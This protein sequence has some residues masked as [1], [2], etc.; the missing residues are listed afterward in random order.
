[1]R[2]SALHP[3]ACVRRRSRYG[4]AA[5][6]ALALLALPA[7][8][9]ATGTPDQSQTRD[10]GSFQ[11]FLQRGIA[12]TFTAGISGALDQVD[13]GLFVDDSCP[14]AGPLTIAIQGVAGG[15]PSGVVLA[16]A[17]LAE[18]NVPAIG[19]GDVVSSVP[20]AVPA[21][22][23]AGT[24]YAIVASAPGAQGDCSAAG[25]QAYSWGTATGD[26]YP[27]GTGL[28]SFDDGVNWDA[29]GGGAID[30]AFT[31]YVSPVDTTAP[32]TTIGLGPSSPDG[33]NGWYVSPVTVTISTSDAS[34]ETRCV[35]DPA[36]VPASF[37]DLPAGCPASQT[38]SA[39]G[40]HVLYAASKDE[41]GNTEQIE[42]ASFKI[43][44]TSPTVTFSS[45]PA[46]Y[47]VDQ[48]VT[49]T[50][51]AADPS[52][53]SGLASNTCGQN[54]LGNVPAY[55]LAAGTH[56]LSATATDNAGNSAAAQTSYSVKV[57]IASLCTLT[58]RF[59]QGSAKYAAL[60]AKQKA[61]V[62]ALGQVTC[63]FLTAIGTKLN[64]K[65]TQV[66]IAGYKAGVGSLAKQGWL[67]TA[68][69]TTL[70]NLTSSL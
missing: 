66:L 18:A 70:R 11:I 44:R 29:Q 23:V 59:V 21:L 27:E 20:F 51:A 49:I 58:N 5:L 50:C 33:Q 32:A 64:A 57:T 19:T 62:N 47:T 39:D 53:G 8:A 26:P 15:V 67:S 37:S 63:G 43:D 68:Q 46:S 31:T 45:H 52:P 10:D 14:P 24:Q 38:V 56:T 61:S 69:A 60:T 6:A 7:V 9:S 41:A 17:T 3:S 12:Q 40:P 48:Q 2:R 22:V 54:S 30:L 4:L 35:V 28:I 25:N 65:Q 13:L 55:T 1:M 42:S 34:A 16:S 36:S